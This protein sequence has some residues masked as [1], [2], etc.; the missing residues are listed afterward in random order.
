MN[1]AAQ[2][3]APQD[4][5]RATRFYYYWLLLALFFEYARPASYAPFLAIPFLYSILPVALLLVSMFVKGLRP[6]GEIFGDPLAKWVLI[7]LGLITFSAVHADVSLYVFNVWKAVVGYAMLFVMVARIATTHARMRGVFVTLMIAHL[8]LLAMNPEVVTDPTTRHYILGA[9]FLGDGN[10]YSLSLCIL[11]PFAIEVALHQKKLWSRILAWAATGMLVVAIIGTQSR[12]ATL[13]MGSVM[14]FLWLLSPRKM[15]SLVGVALVALIVVVY[16]PP[17]Y[18][19]RMGTVKNYEQDGS[20]QGR[21]EAWKG[22]TNM[23]LTYPLT[24]VGA[25]QFPTSFGTKFRTPGA[26]HMPWL[27]AHSSYF[28]VLGELGFPGLLV[29]LTI[30]IGNIRTNLRVRKD[31][32][33]RAGPSPSAQTREDAQMLYLCSAA[34]LGFAVAGAFLSAA[35]YPHIFVLTGLLIA[36]RSIAA[37]RAGIEIVTRS[38]RELA[39]ERRRAARKGAQARPIAAETQSQPPPPGAR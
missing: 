30:V 38:P 9:T 32:L 12:G 36:A 17:A 20:A 37:K 7:F 21:I 2:R 13:G 29:L 22:A 4:P 24:G 33:A 10:D 11:L 3:R 35:Y 18:F 19:Q 1:V 5:E 28:L 8:F 31:V 26:Q 15:A 16:A 6:M 34:M 23:A 39:A 14:I 27:T 25:G